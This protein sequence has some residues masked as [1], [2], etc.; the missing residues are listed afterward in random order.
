[1]QIKKLREKV[2]KLGYQLSVR[3]MYGENTPAYY[4]LVWEHR[5]M[6]ARLYNLEKRIN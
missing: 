5:R 1:M 6:L 2:R 3:E 4:D